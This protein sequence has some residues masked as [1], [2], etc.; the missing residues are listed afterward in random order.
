M[1]ASYLKSRFAAFFLVVF[2]SFAAYGQSGRSGS[3]SGVVT[4]RSGAGLPNAT[5]EARNPVSGFS[6]TTSTDPSGKFTIPNVPFNPYH[7]TIAGT[8]FADYASDI[9]VRS[10][11]PVTLSV[12]LKVGGSAESVTVEASGG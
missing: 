6:R 8:G 9:D 3:I 2:F 1:L 11:V 4:D 10:T 5:V 7:L 12:T